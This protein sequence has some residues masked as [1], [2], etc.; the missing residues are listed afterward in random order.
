MFLFLIYKGFLIKIFIKWL[1]M[2]IKVLIINWLE[3]K[4]LRSKTRKLVLLDPPLPAHF[5]SSEPNI[6]SISN[7][8][9]HWRNPQKCEIHIVVS[10]AGT[11]H[12]VYVVDGSRWTHQACNIGRQF[13]IRY[14]CIVALKENKNWERV[15]K[16]S[17][18]LENTVYQK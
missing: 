18:S 17:L 6:L 7:R 11:S 16:H 10:D 14:S 8:S 2:G 13:I 15:E 1:N 9:H 12:V 4:H 3:Q 5:L